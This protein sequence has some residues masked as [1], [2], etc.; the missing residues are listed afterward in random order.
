MPAKGQAA[1]LLNLVRL[2]AV[3]LVREETAMNEIPK[4]AAPRSVTTGPIIGLAQSLCLPE[5]PRRHPVPFREITLSDR[6]R[7]QSGSPSLRPYTESNITIDL[8][9]GL[10]PGA[11]LG[12]KRG[13]R[14]VEPRPIKP[15]DNCNASPDHLAPLCPARAGCA[16]ESRASSSPSSSSPAPGSSPKR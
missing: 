8:A 7:R 16:P 2:F 11:R 15:E 4:F 14:Q 9:N 6:T 5:R 1:E 3:V 12:S 10:K 13:L